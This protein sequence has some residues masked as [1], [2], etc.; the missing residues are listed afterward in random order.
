MADF[1]DF[2]KNTGGNALSSIEDMGQ[3]ITGAVSGIASIPVSLTKAATN[4]ATG[5]GNFLGSP[6]S[7]ITI[8]ILAIAAIYMFKK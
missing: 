4:L 8:P 3:N 7:G 2:L 5:L 6:L 1:V